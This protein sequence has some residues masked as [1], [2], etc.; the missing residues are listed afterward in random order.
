MVLIIFLLKVSTET[1]ANTSPTGGSCGSDLNGPAVMDACQKV[2][3]RLEPY[4]T[5][6]RQL[7]FSLTDY[8]FSKMFTVISC[9]DIKLESMIFTWWF[10]ITQSVLFYIQRTKL[11]RHFRPIWVW[12]MILALKNW[13]FR[14]Y[15][16]VVRT[17]SNSE[18][19]NY[20]FFFHIFFC[21]LQIEKNIYPNFQLIR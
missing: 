15:T 17:T 7:F 3:A 1:L 6:Q 14:Y 10:C 12:D 2:M 9:L 5:P 13:I 16:S 18:S 20:H 8:I 4:R 19:W 21:F 11:F